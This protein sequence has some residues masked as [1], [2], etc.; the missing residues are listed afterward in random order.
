M[1]KLYHIFIFIS[2]FSLLVW[3][4]YEN[5]KT[6]LS[7][8]TAQRM[9]SKGL[10]EDGFPKIEICISPGFNTNYLKANGYSSLENFALGKGYHKGQAFFGWKG[11]NSIEFEKLFENGY[12]FKNFSSILS[13]YKL[14]FLCVQ[15][16]GGER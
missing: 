5:I 10:I 2:C 6:Y 14:I 13:E 3:Q 7:H 8:P 11:N 16:V 9:S 12:S 4:S 15:R 1:K